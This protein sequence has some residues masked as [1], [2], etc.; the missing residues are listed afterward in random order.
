MTIQLYV[1]G[2]YFNESIPFTPDVAG[3]TTMSG[4]AL[5]T[6]AM[7]HY[8]NFKANL[9]DDGLL[10]QFSY[11]PSGGGFEPQSELTLTQDLTAFFPDCA[12]VLQYTSNLPPVT[13]TSKR[14]PFGT[15][16]FQD[17]SQ[18]RIRLLNIYLPA[19]GQV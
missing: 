5:L 1:V 7:N 15:N 16:G 17:G 2:I 4:N 3:G 9:T 19:P 18:I 13:P 6:A 12:Q 10:D 11:V 14:P 8:T